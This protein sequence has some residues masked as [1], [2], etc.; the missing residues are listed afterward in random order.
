M[1]WSGA[2]KRLRG[3][4]S[5]GHI[6][7]TYTS[8]AHKWL[9]FAHPLIWG[10]THVPQ[11]LEQQAAALAASE[12]AAA[13]AEEQHAAAEDQLRTQLM[14]AEAE[15]ERL[16]ASLR[17]TLAAFQTFPSGSAVWACHISLGVHV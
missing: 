3:E 8:S 2:S 17:A 6:C 13:S 9:P 12:A 15:C 4:S 16:Q 11:E 14:R 5:A 1:S 7:P 10:L